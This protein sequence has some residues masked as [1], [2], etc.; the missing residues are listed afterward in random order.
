MMNDP[1]L[2]DASSSSDLDTGIT[3]SGN[4]SES[5][6]VA[7]DKDVAGVLA[8]VNSHTRDEEG[9]P[10]ESGAERNGDPGNLAR[11]PS[12]PAY[13]VFS[14]GTK[15][16]IIAMVT[17]SSFVSP[18]TANIY[19]PAL[20]PIAKDLGVTVNLINLTLTTYM[21]MQGIAPTLFGDFGDMAGRRPAFIVSFTIYIAANIGL[22][23]QDNYAA[24]MVLRCMQSGGSSGTLALSFAV[25]ADIAV[26]GERGKYMGIVGAGIN[27]GPALSP[28]VGGLLAEYLGWRAIFWFCAIFT[29]SFLVPYILTVPETCRKVVGNGSIPPQGW[30]MSLLDWL[31]YRR[32]PQLERA[33]RQKLRFPNPIKALSVVFEKDV[34]IILFY[35]S[36]LYLVFILV[37]ATLSTQFSEIYHYTNLEVGLCYL[38]YGV[39]CCIA[40]ISQGYILDWN[41]RRIAHNIGFTINMRR[42]DDLSNFPI[43]KARIQ[44]LYPLLVVGLGATIAYGWVLEREPSVAAPLALQFVIGLCITGS[45]GILNTLIVD[46][47]PEAPATAMAANNFVRCECGAVATSVIEIMIRSMGRGWCFTFWALLVVVFSPILWASPKYGIQWRAER[48]LRKEKHRL[49][50]ESEKARV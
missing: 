3:P 18:M 19:F 27:I 25:V 21:I 14:K 20:N 47:Y 37:A 23:L 30:N 16:W 45:F 39:G 5:I 4:P 26:S 43:E 13:S 50:R 29:V 38:P 48:R 9:E 15:R 42:G 10:A 2:N 35:N 46:L 28:V 8:A 24:L 11:V 1:T 31:R 41:Y 33:P 44:P 17:F 32:H 36:L 40:A 22:A 7:D 12:G 6:P 34:G 49:K